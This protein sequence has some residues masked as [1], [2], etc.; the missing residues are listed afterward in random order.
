[1][2]EKEQEMNTLSPKWCDIKQ[3]PLGRFVSKNRNYDN[4]VHRTTML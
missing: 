1:M 3:K 2:D 4:Q